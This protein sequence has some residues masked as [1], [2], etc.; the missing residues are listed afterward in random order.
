VAR[1]YYAEEDVEALHRWMAGELQKDG[2]HVDAFEYCPDHAEATVARYRRTSHR[3]K[4]APG[5]LL[6]CLARWPV[7][8]EESFLIGD[9]ETD[10]AAARAAGIPGYLFPGGDLG[11]FIG[12]LPAGRLQ[13]VDRPRDPGRR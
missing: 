1:G 13:R 11:A 12:A 2:A 9:K 4:P 7:N 8:K 5:M 6:D 10:I 3:R